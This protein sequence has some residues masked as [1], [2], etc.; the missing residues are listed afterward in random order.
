MT[1]GGLERPAS[2]ARRRGSITSAPLPP[3]GHSAALLIKS[4]IARDAVQPRVWTKPDHLSE[5]AGQLG[6]RHPIGPG[7]CPLEAGPIDDGND[8]AI[9]RYETGFFKKA[10]RHC[11]AGATHPA[12]QT[13]IHG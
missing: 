13:G 1:S 6:L 4:T 5:N 11:N 2:L 10:Q 3:A 9:G 7:G 12:S 8:A